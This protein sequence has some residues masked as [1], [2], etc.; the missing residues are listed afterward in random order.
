MTEPPVRYQLGPRSRRGLVAGW[1]AGQLAVVGAGLAMAM[2]VV[3]SAGA[4]GAVLALL[5]VAV[6]VASVTWPLAGRS[7]EQWAPVV[8][9]HAAQRFGLRRHRPFDGF[10]LE[11][12]AFGPGGRQFG[13]IVDTAARTRTAALRVDGAGFALCDDTERS[14][15][16]AAWSSVLAGTAREGGHLHRL[17]WLACCL[18]GDSASAV[19]GSGD[20]PPGA[21]RSYQ[22]LLAEVGPSL[23]SHDLVVA[24][25]VSTS[26]RRPR[27]GAG[28]DR[29]LVQELTALERRLVAAGLHAGG[30]LTR[31]SL[32]EFV[33]R[34][35]L[36]AAMPGAGQKDG[37]WPSDVAEGW[38]SVRTDGAWHAVY[39]V[40]E[41]P[42]AAVGAGFLLP[43]L[44][45]GGLRRTVSVTMAPL[46]PLAAV[47]RAE[48]DRTSGFADAEL[49]RRHGFAVTA[50]ARHE[51]DATTRREA[52]LAEGHG[53]FRFTGYLAVTVDSEAE[54]GDA[55]ARLEQ[56]AAQAQLEV[57][58]MYGSQSAGLA[59][60]LP[61]GR[62]LS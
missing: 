28:G 50:R 46:S 47:R 5:I 17:Q 61:C 51:H 57:H 25:S 24:V 37:T 43:M 58:R 32:H 34:R 55:C 15:L 44:L 49:R 39:W 19:P 59:C 2:V 48:H 10:S 62:G 35:W 31:S 9:S 3:R 13:V 1:R 21:V 23:W 56:L 42:R 6:L 22:S 30:P 8:A 40:A 27:A 29:L 38:S 18:P 36:P 45:D 53:A 54:L 41:W 26:R 4:A 33:R 11:E 16:I 12:T 20:G 52:E 14:R 60:V 7:A